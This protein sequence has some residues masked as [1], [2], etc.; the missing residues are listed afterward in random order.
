MIK[1]NLMTRIILIGLATAFLM[2]CNSSTQNKKEVSMA[3]QQKTGMVE[4]T[5]FKLNQGVTAKDFEQSARA[6]QKDFLEKQNGF[7]K[8]TLTV[9]EDNVWTDLVFWT[10]KESH[11]NAM[12]LAE[13]TEA[14]VPF[15]EKI[16]FNSVKMN[17]TTPV[18]IEE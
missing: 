15:M 6:M 11:G 8:R 4:I 1:L 12:Q 2:S 3:Q 9:S 5:T 14:V 7:I 18:I 17:L 13:K 16:D 10:N